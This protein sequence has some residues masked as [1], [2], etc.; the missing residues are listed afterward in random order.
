MLT[1]AVLLEQLDRCGP[2]KTP[3][4]LTDW[5][6]KGFLPRL[7]Q[8]GTGRGRGAS[9]G[10]NDPDIL[11]RAILV[12]DLLEGGV[13]GE[14]VVLCAWFAGHDID[15]AI[16]RKAWL[17]LVKD[18]PLPKRF[19]DFE[20]LLGSLSRKASRAMAPQFGAAADD[21]DAFILEALNVFYQ[22]HYSF[23][24]YDNYGFV[25]KA[26]EIFFCVGKIE[27]GVTDAM[28]Q[29]CFDFIRDGLSIVSRERFLKSVSDDE[30]AEAHRRWRL[31]LRHIRNLIDV[32]GVETLAD[33]IDDLGRRL[34]LVAGPWSILALLHLARSPVASNL[35]EAERVLTRRPNL[36]PEDVFAILAHMW[37]R[38]DAQA[39]TY[40]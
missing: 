13:R 9:F 3:R 11:E 30:L 39:V 36:P 35:K 25:E 34:K 33:Q 10:W 27:P 22:R 1:Q 38:R 37:D 14:Q 40:D 23:D 12:D 20:D 21:L 6:A 31:V 7:V 2:P 16:V 24:I 29:Q 28:L 5:R 15:L 19:C 8:H 4:C 18:R 17:A 32:C 26:N